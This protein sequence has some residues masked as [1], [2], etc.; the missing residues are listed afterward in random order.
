MTPRKEYEYAEV[1]VDR[2][3]LESFANEQSPYHANNQKLP[4]RSLEK[5]RSKLKWHVSHSLSLR[6]KQVMEFYLKG[7]TER[8]IARVLGIT[9]QVVN[10]YKHRAIR[11]LHKVFVS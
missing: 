10:I 1:L 11:K 9:Q 6:Q 8:E 2:L 5:F 7:K 4:A 3:L